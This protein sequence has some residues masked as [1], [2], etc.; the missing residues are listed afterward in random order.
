M[1]LNRSVITP[2]QLLNEDDQL[3]ISNPPTFAPPPIID[4]MEENKDEEEL[5]GVPT[6]QG[7]ISSTEQYSIE[8]PA[9]FTRNDILHVHIPNQVLKVKI[10]PHCGPGSV[11][12]IRVSPGQ[13]CYEYVE[14]S[15]DMT[16]PRLLRPQNNIYT[17]RRFE[18]SISITWLMIGLLI[19]S[20]LISSFAVRIF[21]SQEI[22]DGCNQTNPFSGEPITNLFYVLGEGLCSSPRGVTDTYDFCI[23]F[24]DRDAWS[25]IDR[26]VE[27]SGIA[28]TYRMVN[29]VTHAWK[30]AEV[31]IPL[32]FAF[33]TLAVLFI[34]W[35]M[36]QK[37]S[38]AGNGFNVLLIGSSSLWLIIS[39]ALA[40]SAYNSIWLSDSMSPFIWQRFYNTGTSF[41]QVLAAGDQSSSS[42]DSSCNVEIEIGGDEGILFLVIAIPIAFFLSLWILCTRCCGGYD[43]IFAYPTGIP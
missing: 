17:Y 40:I 39:W 4:K 33:C 5:S 29:D 32:S 6:V 15:T 23:S 30:A 24:V 3:E 18:D 1:I 16:P 20:M 11:F 12:S 41:G 34:G 26:A 22:S 27:N 19:T 7:Y 35:G 8:V 10:P 25:R 37:V 9:G 13:Q 28:R 21:S 38:A 2:F 43:D 36:A 14:T 31:M 42:P